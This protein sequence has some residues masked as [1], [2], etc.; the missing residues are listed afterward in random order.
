MLW[1]IHVHEQSTCIHGHTG[2]CLWP[3]KHMKQEV[4][5]IRT[6]LLPWETKRWHNMNCTVAAWMQV[7]SNMICSW[8]NTTGVIGSNNNLLREV[9]VKPYLIYYCFMF[10]Y[11]LPLCFMISVSVDRSL[12]FYLTVYPMPYLLLSFWMCL[13]Y[14]P[15]HI[16]FFFF[17]FCPSVYEQKFPIN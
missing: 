13:A 11:F 1:L 12:F 15:N 8:S 3:G 7:A 6:P 14:L 9:T 5:Q 16:L 17:F 4:Q 10:N 2:G